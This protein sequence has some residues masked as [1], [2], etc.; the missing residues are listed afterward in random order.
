VPEE[1]APSVVQMRTQWGPAA[2]GAT[3]QAAGPQLGSRV[4]ERN[5]DETHFLRRLHPH[6]HCLPAPGLRVGHGLARSAPLHPG[7]RS[8]L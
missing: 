1:H 7:G 4:A 5:C 2:L 3:I 6:Q 8:A